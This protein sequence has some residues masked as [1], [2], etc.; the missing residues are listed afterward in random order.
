MTDPKALVDGLRDY[1]NRHRM[2]MGMTP[3]SDLI[4][5]AASYIEGTIAP[6]ENADSNS[7]DIGDSNPPQEKPRRGRRKAQS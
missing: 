1:A 2:M 3:E 4:D 6:V 7:P 5:A